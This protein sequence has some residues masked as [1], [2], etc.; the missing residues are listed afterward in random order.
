MAGAVCRYNGARLAYEA[1]YGRRKSQGTRSETSEESEVKEDS[2]VKDEPY[3]LEESNKPVSDDYYAEG[4]SAD[5]PGVKK[6]MRLAWESDRERLI[7]ALGEDVVDGLDLLTIEQARE[8]ASTGYPEEREAIER[9]LNAKAAYDGVIERVRDDI[10][11]EVRKNDAKIDMFTNVDTGTVIEV[12]LTD[13]RQMWV[14]SGKLARLDNGDVDRG[15]SSDMLV[16]V[17]ANGKAESTAP[18][19][20]ARV[21]NEVDPAELKRMAA[22]KISNEMAERA[23]VEIDGIVSFAPGERVRML[24]EEGGEPVEVVISGDT[25]DEQGA[26]VAGMVDVVMPDG[27]VMSMSRDDVQRG[28]DAADALRVSQARALD[29]TDKSDESY[30]SYKPE[31]VEI[32]PVGRGKFGDV[33]ASFRGK[34]KAAL[35]YLSRLKSGQAKGVFYR[36]EIGEIDLVW[37][38][39]PTAYSGKGLAHIDRKH[40]QTLGDFS[41]MEEA[42]EV[43]DDVIK[44]GAFT[45]Q[46]ARTAVFDKDNYRVVVARDEA[47]NWVLTAFDNKT[48][49]REK[50][51]QKDA[52][53]LGTAGQPIEGARA[54]TPNLSALSERLSPDSER[55]LTET[56]N[57]SERPDLVPTSDSSLSGDKV[58]TN[59]L[60][61]QERVSAVERV[62]R[63]EQ[64]K[65]MLDAVEPGL[66][67][68]VIEEK[69]PDGGSQRKFIENQIKR[70]KANLR[71]A[72][73]ARSVDVD[74]ID[75]FAEAESAR[76][77]AIEQAKQKVAHWEAVEKAR[78][79]RIEEAR[80]VREAEERRR[81]EERYQ[82]EKAAREEAELAAAAEAQW[83][84]DKKNFDKRLREV[85]EELKDI[86]EALTILEDTNPQTIE[87]VAAYLLSGHKV[88]WSDKSRAGKTLKYGVKS[89]VGIGE[90]E[91]RK[92]FGLFASEAKGGVSIEKLSED[93][94]KEVCDQYG[95]PYDN[96]AAFN[97]L[98][99]VIRGARTIGDIRNYITN[100]RIEQARR[101]AQ[102]Y[103]DY[104]ER[105]N[106]AFYQENLKIGYE[107][108]RDYEEQLM[109]RFKDLDENLGDSDYYDIFVDEIIEQN[110]LEDGITREEETAGGHRVENGGAEEAEP[111][112]IHSG[113]GRG[114]EVLPAEEAIVSGRDK[115]VAEP[116][117]GNEDRSIELA[118]ER[119]VPESTPGRESEIK[120]EQRGGAEEP[121]GGYPR[122]LF[123]GDEGGVQRGL[124]DEPDNEFSA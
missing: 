86:P 7:A 73:N 105:Q 109:A 71:E 54:V 37:G 104:N 5:E 12:R 116:R 19:F 108:Y 81:A 25:V 79:A 117:A 58:T 46:N 113:A 4:Y 24:T 27:S 61:E 88:L 103:F 119:T 66:A 17:G 77:G 29:E 99:D 94:F 111:G 56:P 40:V 32:K 47:G 13:G 122:S 44:N 82:A 53:A 50:K 84:Q 96:G 85:A 67:L 51:E 28:A 36:P 93:Y 83:Q 15:N 70:S 78:V 110:E 114:D 120:G 20:I 33:F 60:P 69:L 101:V 95:V 65:P 124:F 41:S 106:E 3:Q 102:D 18:N 14:T 55:R 42:I 31:E 80:K 2:E 43:I 59:N 48:S 30:G 72:E 107:E 11:E 8:V 100:N 97:A 112:G 90:G 52:A 22:G 92:L 87:E 121:G 1:E 21:E 62:P 63:D 35:E 76:L 45:E 39:A 6:D 64:G 16:V 23:S 123:G 38:D 91:R 115:E 26:P 34:A 98:I 75:A 118:S 49:A 10:S 68:D 9:Y 89:H 57:G 74:D